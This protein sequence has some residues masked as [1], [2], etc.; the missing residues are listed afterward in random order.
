MGFVFPLVIGKKKWLEKPD[1]TQLPSCQNVGH[2]VKREVGIAQAFTYI[3][4]GRCWRAGILKD[5]ASSL[6]KENFE[7]AQIFALDFDSCDKTPEE[8]VEYCQTI[9]I[10]PNFWYWSFSQGGKKPKNNFLMCLII[11]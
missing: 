4:E 5:G 10:P 9:T 7:G 6:K 8:I 1:N 3:T 2:Y 11:L